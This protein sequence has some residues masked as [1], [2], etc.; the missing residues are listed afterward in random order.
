MAE[1]R[2][3][4]DVLGV[5]R[6][7]DEK[8]IKGA[9]H[10]LALRY[11]PD[12]SQEPDAEERFKEIAEA[13]AVLGNAKKRAEYDAGGF[14]GVTGMHPEDLFQ[15]ADF[16]DL[17]GG[18]GLGLD[19][20]GLGGGGLFDRLFGGQR[21]GPARGS[22]VVLRVE[23][24]L[25]TVVNGADE[26]LSVDHPRACEPCQG[27]G[28]KPGTKPRPCQACGGSGRKASVRQ[29]GNVHFQTVT[30][31]TECQGRGRFIDEPCDPC[32]G[33]GQVAEHETLT[34][35]IP[36]GVKEGMML[37]VPG[38]GSPPP[39]TGGQPGDLL[40]AVHTQP[41]A[42]FERRGP[43]LW[44]AEEI[45]PSD[46]VLGTSVRVPTLDGHARLSVPAGTQPG[47]V[48]RLPGKG[49][50]EFGSSARGD[51]FVAVRVRIP[52]QLSGEEKKL[53]KRLRALKG[54]P[55]AS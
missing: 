54:E 21:R 47:T 15:G 39:A 1:R 35:K 32:Q 49:L 4:Y 36:P 9:F 18:L 55:E 10:Q 43:H 25:E 30:T 2:D 33:R 5:S 19:L 31:C 20:G 40:V 50:P 6:D 38:K 23:V 14:A 12:R 44:R 53:W 7:A 17:F 29:Q 34:V 24:P 37:R 51:L 48:L 3:Y 16:E 26:R 22:D 13:Y 46:A 52:E 8:A 41:D 27:T 45:N 28:A 11:H 42:R